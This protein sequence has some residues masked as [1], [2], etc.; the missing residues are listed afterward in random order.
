MRLQKSQFAR[1]AMTTF[2]LVAMLAGLQFALPAPAQAADAAD[3]D[4][5]MLITDSAFFNGSAMTAQQVDDFIDNRNPGCLTTVCL[6]NYKENV[7]AKAATSKCKAIPAATKQTAGQIISTVGKA[8][9]ISPKAILVILQKE[10]SLVTNRTPSARSF[11]YAMGAG[12]PDSTGC[13]TP[14]QGLY[15][16]VYYGASLLK[17]YT[18][19][20]SSNYTRYQA[21][22]TSNIL[23]DTT[24]GCGTRAVFVRNQ[25]THALYVYTPYTPNKAALKNL[26]GTGDSC[27]AYG[28]RNFWRMYI[29]WFGATGVYG[30]TEIIE[31]WN[32]N[33][34][35]SGAIG[36]IKAAPVLNKASGGGYYQAFANGTIAWTSAEGAALVA[37]PLN[38]FWLKT[39]IETAGWPVQSTVT[40]T[41]GGGGVL[42][43]TTKGTMVQPT[44]LSAMFM[45]SGFTA[46]WEAYGGPGGFVGWPKADKTTLRTGLY[47]QQFDNGLV[48]AD[49]TVYGWV[50]NTLVADYLARGDVASALGWPTGNYA[51]STAAGGIGSQRFKNGMLLNSTDYGIRA[52]TGPIFAAYAKVGGRAK[53]G[54]PTSE[55]YQYGDTA[56]T[57]QDFEKASIISDGTATAIVAKDLVDAAIANGVFGG[58]L[59][60]PTGL[61][62]TS[63]ANGGGVAQNFVGGK[64][65][66]AT[67]GEAAFVY[68]GLLTAWNA[69]G[70]TSGV[71]GWPTAARYKDPVLGTTNQDFQGGTVFHNN[72]KWAAVG[73]NFVEAARARGVT[74]DAL[75]WPL[76]DVVK[77]S[78]NGGGEV[79]TFTVG[80]LTW[81]KSKGNFLVPTTVWAAVKANGGVSGSKIGWPTAEASW[82]AA[83]KTYT[84]KFQFATITCVTGKTCTV[85]ATS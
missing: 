65:A 43:R 2:A 20:S 44:G 42:Q 12:C 28:N 67:D 62:A 47:T 14:Y 18:L 37:K 7:T 73:T 3:F 60:L 83:K 74:T 4:P 79:Q 30:E 13:N 31:F 15:G 56:Y 75:G 85:K 10:Q 36:E 8:C 78:K 59:G 55:V 76:A 17:G 63:S 21:G 46:A 58:K 61:P 50:H 26:Y 45:K 84:Q 11:A 48:F 64:L 22:K 1:L 77:T 54:W 81:Q 6:E 40:S 52:V 35:G 32:A 39:T 33:G 69:K 57:V 5:G 24:A 51:P 38:T 41:A 71:L 80:T 34:G 25:A 23:Y 27:S 70:R 66:K 72:K 19:P 68:G 53:I 49:G 9:G 82:N 29:D 16:Q